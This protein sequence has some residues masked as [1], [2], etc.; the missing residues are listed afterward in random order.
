LLNDI[1]EEYYINYMFSN[2]DHAKMILGVVC[3]ILKL[4]VS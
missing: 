2:G 4:S 1:K 3:N